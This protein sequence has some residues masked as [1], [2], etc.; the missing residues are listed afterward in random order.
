MPVGQALDAAWR[1]EFRPLR[2]Q[3]GNGV[4]LVAQ[5]AA[6]LGDAFSL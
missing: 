5:F 1:I 3:N 2:A 4:A 6:Y